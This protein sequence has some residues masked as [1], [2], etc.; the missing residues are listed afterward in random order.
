MWEEEKNAR[1]AIAEMLHE[2]LTVKMFHCGDS[3]HQFG[4]AQAFE[5]EGRLPEMCYPHLYFPL[6]T[7]CG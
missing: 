6:L 5:E 7:S 2:K 4:R 1:R 3:G